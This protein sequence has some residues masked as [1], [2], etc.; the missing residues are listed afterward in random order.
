MLV[1]EFPEKTDW[2]LV[3]VYY[4]G[5]NEPMWDLTH[6]RHLPFLTGIARRALWNSTVVGRDIITE[7]TIEF[8]HYLEDERPKK[9]CPNKDKV[10]RYLGSCVKYRAFNAVKK[11]KKSRGLVPVYGNSNW[12][13]EKRDSLEVGK[14]EIQ[15]LR[16]L[17]E[18]DEIYRE[19]RKKLDQEENEFIDLWLDFGGKGKSMKMALEMDVSVEEVNNTKKRL[20]RKIRKIVR[21]LLKNLSD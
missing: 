11:M 1:T 12:E 3:V 6:R 10:R 2:E 13:E 7:M 17:F 9:F 16:N 5:E 20:R 14:N 8:C 21:P 18:I 4:K 19:I 15:F